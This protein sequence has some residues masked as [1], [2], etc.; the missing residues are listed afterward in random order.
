M[1]K[2][3]IL[4]TVLILVLVCLSACGKKEAD[5][6]SKDNLLGKWTFVEMPVIKC[7]NAKYMYSVGYDK[8]E[9]FSDGSAIENGYSEKW[10]AE[11]GRLKIGDDVSSYEL[12]GDK[13]KVTDDDGCQRIYERN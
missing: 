6:N 9:L 3:K 2:K 1:K 11:N 13:L 8:L 10:I 5:S 12:S 7:E 4:I